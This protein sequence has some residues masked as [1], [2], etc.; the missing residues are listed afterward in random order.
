MPEGD[1]LHI[2]ANTLRPALVGKVVKRI[3]FARLAGDSSILVGATVIEVEAEGKN[4]LVRFDSGLVLHTHLKM[5][6]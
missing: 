1:T 5:R 3:D 6:G 4:L 2:T